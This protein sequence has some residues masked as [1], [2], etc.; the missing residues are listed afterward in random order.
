MSRRELQEW[1]FRGC[2]DPNTLL[3]NGKTAGEV[4]LA[5]VR[6]YLER[7]ERRTTR[8]IQS[9]T[10]NATANAS[11]SAN[12]NGNGDGETT[13]GLLVLPVPLPN[14]S[15]TWDGSIATEPIR[16]S[17]SQFPAETSGTS[18]VECPTEDSSLPHSKTGLL[19]GGNS[20]G[21]RRRRRGRKSGNAQ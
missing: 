4:A 9:V 6:G 3:S 17:E 16:P 2:H 13:S 1:Y 5:W 7:Q 20:D 12:G 14:P 19:E 15:G 8:G 18:Y 10:V 11:V 21:N